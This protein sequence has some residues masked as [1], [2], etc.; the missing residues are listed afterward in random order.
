[1]RPLIVYF[2]LV[3][4]ATC[5]RAATAVTDADTLILNDTIFRLEG[6][7]GPRTDQVCLDDAGA[8]WSCG[9]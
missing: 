8:K 4:T 2:V 5:A 9:I 1:M 6:I 3:A 7:E